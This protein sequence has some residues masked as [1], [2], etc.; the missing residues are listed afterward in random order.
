MHDKAPGV[1]ERY[2]QLDE[3]ETRAGLANMKTILFVCTANICRSPMAE[4]IFNALAEERGLA[5]R[6]QSA[7]VA[8]LIDENIAPHARTAL[9]EVGIYAE[10]HHARQVSE[11]MLEE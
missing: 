11:E 5:W 8:A 4:A 7:G 6:A 2:E 1:D 3:G 10:T 9:E